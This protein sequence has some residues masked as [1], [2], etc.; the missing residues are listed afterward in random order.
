MS[1]MLGVAFGSGI[2]AL[3][4]FLPSTGLMPFPMGSLAPVVGLLLVVPGALVAGLFA[5]SSGRGAL[6]GVM[7]ALP[8]YLAFVTYGLLM[9]RAP[10]ELVVF[11]GL[12]VVGVALLAGSAVGAYQK[13]RI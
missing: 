2:T 10:I 9:V 7:T 4:L 11:Y 6:N 13:T 1:Q 5:H 3:L 12:L 8:P